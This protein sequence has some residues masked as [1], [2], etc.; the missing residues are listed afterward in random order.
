MR[1]GMAVLMLA[2]ALAVVGCGLFG[3][4]GDGG[5]PVEI[6]QEIVD[7]I[8]QYGGSA[9]LDTG[10]YSPTAEAGNE[11]IHV[12]TMYAVQTVIGV[13]SPEVREFCASEHGAVILLNIA[14]GLACPVAKG[15]L[16]A[17]GWRLVEYH[18]PDP[19]DGYVG[20]K[21]YIVKGDTVIG[22]PAGAS[23]E[24]EEATDA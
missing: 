14:N 6:P 10:W 24:G 8:I 22:Q 17:G 7:L 16:R 4:G 2:A 13:L 1:R 9:D 11:A 18:T 19:A 23:G 15:A 21:Y 12:A 3:G 5:E 20:R